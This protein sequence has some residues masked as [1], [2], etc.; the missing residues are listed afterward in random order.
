M[1]V[2]RDEW[3]NFTSEFRSKWR[4]SGDITRDFERYEHRS[5]F[6]PRAQDPKTVTHK[7]PES[8]DLNHPVTKKTKIMYRR[9]YRRRSRLRRRLYGR[10]RRFR[11][12]SKFG[13]RR[14]W[15]TRVRRAAIRMNESKRHI[16]N[17]STKTGIAENV[18]TTHALAWIDRQTTHTSVDLDK[19][20]RVGRFCNLTGVKL[21][22][23]FQ[24]R[25]L[26]ESVL[27]RVIVHAK[28]QDHT[29][30]EKIFK[31][32]ND[33]ETVTLSSWLTA[34]GTKGAWMSMDA[35][36]D[37]KYTRVFYDRKFILHGK[38][39]ASEGTDV[40]NLKVWIPFHNRPVKYD[41]DTPTSS[42]QLDFSPLVT[43]YCCKGDQTS[44]GATALVDYSFHNI[45]YFKDP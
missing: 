45:T 38:D 39:D 19:T 27:V 20:Q 43:W 7:R 31:A 26:T 16:T 35:P 12:R 25:V 13:S 18:P 28:R 17:L 3:N 44:G 15:G 21:N 11:F 5:K 32:N 33:E 1:N 9:R 8:G 37:R 41:V 14:R 4:E 10:G 29:L 42:D 6:N 36:I 23:Y 34:G 24:N 30:P 40:L 22:W 2:I